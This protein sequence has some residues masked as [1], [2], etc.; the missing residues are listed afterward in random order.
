MIEFMQL[1][2]C[3]MPLFFILFAALVA[4]IIIASI[5]HGARHRKMLAAYAASRG[6]AFAQHD[7]FDIPQRYREFALMKHGHSRRASNVIYGTVGGRSLMLFEYQY[8]TGSG[9]NSTTHTYTALIWTLPVPL[10]PLA[11]R[12]E[13]LFDGVAEWFGHNDIDFESAE[14]S[15]RYHVKGDDRREVYAVFHPRMIEYLMASDL[16]YLE[17]LGSTAMLYRSEGS[18]T[19]QL[20]D[21]FMNLAAGFDGQLPEHLLREKG[22]VAHG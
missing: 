9:K 12:P 14:F 1:T 4:A 13:S 20:G 7:P 22:A 15:R 17:V 21:W 2:A 19:P 10:S 18:V 16:K 11:V 8:T 3:G 6:L 5:V